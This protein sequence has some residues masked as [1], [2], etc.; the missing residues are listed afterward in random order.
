ME[1]LKA[2][3]K[4]TLEWEVTERLT[5]PRGEFKVFSTPSMCMFAEMAAHKLVAPHL[6]PA[7]VTNIL[8]RAAAR[9]EI[10]ADAAALAHADL[11]ALRVDLFP[12]EPF[13]SRVWELRENLTAYDAWYVALAEALSAQL[14]TLDGA[15]RRASGPRCGFLTPRGGAP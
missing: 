4:D 3:M 11:L 5:T 13:A 10:S 14:A 9:G 1:S 8:R 2:G 12:Y 15:L 7:E 6:M